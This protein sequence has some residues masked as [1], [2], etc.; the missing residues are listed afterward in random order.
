MRARA[1]DV[2]SPLRT[3][4]EFHEVD[5]KKTQNCWTHLCARAEAEGRKGAAA[6]VL[7]MERCVGVRTGHV[8]LSK[9][10]FYFMKRFHFHL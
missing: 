1:G 2:A 10:R 6:H 7:R 4:S 9:Q 3:L 8:T 5:L